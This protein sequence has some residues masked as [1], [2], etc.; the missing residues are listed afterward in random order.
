MQYTKE[1]W[2]PINRTRIELGYFASSSGRI[3]T[4][5][6]I[7]GVLKEKYLTQSETQNGYLIVSL[8]YE[9]KKSG[10]YFSHRIIAKTF[11]GDPPSSGHQVNHK[12][13]VKTDNRL[14]NLEWVT[15][16]EN[17]NHAIS[18]GLVNHNSPT[19][20]TPIVQMKNGNIIKE[21]KSQKEAER[22]TGFSQS[23][24]NHCLRGRCRK[25]KGFQW[26]YK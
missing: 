18:T 1:I 6:H 8:C 23:G 22:E 14:E 11:L 24:I 16:D 4:I 9:D 15:R 3:K 26:V 10:S 17:M 2:K 20:E 21:Y 13:G 5:K 7:K 25:F 19:F 12:N